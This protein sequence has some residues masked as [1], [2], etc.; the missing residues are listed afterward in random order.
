MK[1]PLGA[2]FWAL[3]LVTRTSLAGELED[4]EESEA[5]A[6]EAAPVAA[7][8]PVPFDK[9]WLEPYFASGPVRVAADLFRAGD[10]VT[11]TQH[12]TRVLAAMPKH[13]PE[14]NQVR[15]LLALAQMNQN[16]WQ[17]AGDIFE[18][19]WTSYPALAPYHAY[20]AAR[21]RLRKGDA[22]AALL[23]V[24]RVPAKTVLEAEAILIKIDALIAGKRW[25]EVESE[26][27]SFL[28]RFPAG[29]RR[30]EAR[31]RHAEAMQ[32]MKLPPEEI[33]PALRRIWA[34]APTEVWANRSDENL[35]IFAKAAIPAKQA[36]FTTHSAEEWTTRGMGFFDKNQNPQAEAAFTAALTAPGIDKAAECVARFHRAQSVW[37]QRQR[38]RAAPLFAEAEA[39]CQRGQNRDLQVRSLYQGARCLASAGDRE[40]AVAQYALIES[41][42]PE[43]RLADDARLRA[44][45]VLVDGE[46]NEGAEK[47]LSDLPDRYPKGDMAPEA[48]WRLAFAAW[49]GGD[50]EKS[51]SWLNEGIRR[52]P[53]EEIYYAA[54]RAH[55]WKG[56][57]FE[58]Q[59]DK[60]AAL[61]AYTR[62][63]KEY[64]LSLYAL[65]ALE[66]MR[67]SFPKARASL[68]HELRPSLATGKK[69]PV[70][71]FKPQSLFAEPG[72]LRAVELARMG[73][74]AEARRELARLG[75]SLKDT[76]SQ[77]VTRLPG[78][79]DGYW[80]TA[81]LLDRGR[82]W[83]AS[84]SIP[85]YTLTGY[86]WSYPTDGQRDAR[87][88]LAFPRAFPE[89][90]SKHSKANQ[91]P[92]PLQL[93]IMREESAFYPKA[94]SFAN[95]LGL[96]Q[97]LVRTAQRFATWR[98][99]HD[100]LLDPAKN[101]ECG[102]RFLAFLLEHFDRSLPLTIAGYNAGEGAVDRWLRERGTLELDEFLETI[103]Y[104][105]TRNYT[106]RVLASVLTY[107]WLYWPDQPVPTISFTL[108]KLEAKKP[109]KKPGEAKKP[110]KPAPKK[111]GATTG[112]IK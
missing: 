8:A 23:W 109:E 64:P 12:L 47:L 14:H 26:T 78:G 35:Q 19:L 32:Q 34:E 103:P 21:C 66:R 83:S 102:S 69:Q 38:T 54:G 110:E 20:Y 97:M 94:E 7:R 5:G 18:D 49:R 29:P 31:F 67:Q 27:Q 92:E 100:L 15:F 90:V 89:L 99:T 13:A 44:A 61:Q 80:I 106:K 76:E 45:E 87:W 82:L 81:I 39:A 42:F 91:V 60:N 70:W 48:P 108:P 6:E 10:F 50:L 37:K 59:G 95:A 111:P 79:E 104:D 36:A 4:S 16:A 11:A 28:D 9:R 75:L 57:I 112:K 25:A 1:R 74:G 55:Y 51:L 40:K 2:A 107:S 33:A 84:H 65:L 73:L 72:F 43:H 52:F 105:E 101:L 86:R 58:K 3:L 17:V 98:V 62:A 41:Q 71:D 77:G 22:E 46:D 24:T 96:T 85:R 63:V 56:R 53:R 30:A 88:R 68:L 93:A